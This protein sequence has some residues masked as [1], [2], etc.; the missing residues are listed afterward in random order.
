MELLMIIGLG[1]SAVLLIKSAV[2]NHQTLKLIKKQ[3]S[4]GNG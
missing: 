2:M 1:I 4:C 3:K